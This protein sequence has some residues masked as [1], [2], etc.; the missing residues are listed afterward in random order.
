MFTGLI[1]GIGKVTAVDRSGQDM[2]LTIAP[3][4]DMS[5]CRVG[6]SICVSGICL[7]ATGIQEGFFS[8]YA[9]AE[10][11]SRSTLGYIRH[12]DTVNLERAMR[13]SDRMGGH[14]VSGHVDGVGRII[15]MSQAQR[16]WIIRVEIESSLAR[17]TIEKGSVAMDGISLTINRCDD[18][19]F[20]VNIIPETASKTTL[21]KKRTGDLLNIET[22]IIAKYIEKLIMKDK[23]SSGIDMKMLEAFGFGEKLK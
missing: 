12:G 15:H 10:T 17:Y 13:L 19:S 22:D 4:F 6:D 7:T 23:A 3:D 1:E 2:T 20:E 8:A 9:S 18:R 5:D 16:S 14:I 21:M 11:I